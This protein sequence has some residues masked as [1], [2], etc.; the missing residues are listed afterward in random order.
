MGKLSTYKN[1]VK[2]KDTQRHHDVPQ[3]SLGD[4]Q[5]ILRKN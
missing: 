4:I 2:C 3:E 1:I 5:D